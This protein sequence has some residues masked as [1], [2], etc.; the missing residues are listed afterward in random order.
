MVYDDNLHLS[1]D[2]HPCTSQ[3]NLKTLRQI[4]VEP[5]NYAECS[6]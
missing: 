3:I 1:T 5:W 6:T 2:N 4:A